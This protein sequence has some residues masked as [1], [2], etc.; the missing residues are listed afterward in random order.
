MAGFIDFSKRVS[1][2]VSVTSQGATEDLFDSVALLPE[3]KAVVGKEEEQGSNV[4]DKT[5]RFAKGQFP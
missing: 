5:G 3:L 4:N 2:S 1:S